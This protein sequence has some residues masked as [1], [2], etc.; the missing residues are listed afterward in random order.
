MAVA[1]CTLGEVSLDARSNPLPSSSPPSL[2]RVPGEAAGGRGA[3]CPELPSTF[4]VD[5][6]EQWCSGTRHITTGM[7]DP[8]AEEEGSG[9]CGG[10]LLRS[11]I[12]E[13][14]QE[15]KELPKSPLGPRA[16]RGGTGGQA[17]GAQSAA[18]PP[19]PLRF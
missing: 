19:Q 17:S 14:H 16:P 3:G 10:L 12:N 2:P 7:A 18:W 11:L 1:V 9:G 13:T 15:P 5:L 6:S 4:R 8:K